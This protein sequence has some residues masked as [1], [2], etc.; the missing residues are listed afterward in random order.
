MWVTNIGVTG[1]KCK[2]SN[3]NANISSNLTNDLQI[4][5]WYIFATRDWNVI[6]TLRLFKKSNIFWQT[7]V[8]FSQWLMMRRNGKKVNKI[9]RF[10]RRQKSI[11]SAQFTFILITIGT[12]F[13][14]ISQKRKFVKGKVNKK[15]VADFHSFSNDAHC[16]FLKLNMIFVAPSIA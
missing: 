1:T 4:F 15:I 16:L 12:I 14:L 3:V 9:R 6:C 7:I 8:K 5:S 2:R 10:K 13:S 11:I